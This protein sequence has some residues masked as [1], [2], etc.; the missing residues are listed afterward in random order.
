[1]CRASCWK[2]RPTAQTPNHTPSITESPPALLPPFFQEAQPEHFLA[3][4]VSPNSGTTFSQDL[5]QA[6]RHPVAVYAFQATWHQSDA[7]LRK[8]AT[9]ENCAG[10]F[11]GDCAKCPNPIA[12]QRKWR[13]MRCK[14]NP[15]AISRMLS[16]LAP[17]SISIRCSLNPTPPLAPT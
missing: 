17:T 3:H 12:M 6:E 15:I 11:A 1:M 8:L 13:P 2:L 14:K 10:Y 7:I 4:M 16:Y 9:A 5:C